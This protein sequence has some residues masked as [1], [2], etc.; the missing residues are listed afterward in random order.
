MC[1]CLT[2]LPREPG[3]LVQLRDMTRASSWVMVKAFQHLLLAEESDLKA[4][5][6]KPLAAAAASPAPPSSTATITS[7]SPSPLDPTSSRRASSIALAGLTTSPSNVNQAIKR[8]LSVAQMSSLS[9]SG[10]GGGAREED[11]AEMQRLWRLTD[12]LLMAFGEEAVLD[13]FL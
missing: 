11:N 6:A 7:P 8:R 4:S 10:G 1:M 3:L 13:S 9:S 12:A 5:Q 2:F